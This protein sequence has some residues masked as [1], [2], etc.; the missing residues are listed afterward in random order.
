MINKIMKIIA[1]V[2]SNYNPYAIR[3]EKN[4]F[5]SLEG[6]KYRQ[7]PVK[8]LSLIQEIN[9][10][11]NDTAKMIY[12]TSFGKYQIMGYNIYGTCGYK[13]DIATFLC[14]EEHQSD[15]ALKYLQSLMVNFDNVFSSLNTL[16]K[17]KKGYMAEKKSYEEFLKNLS[18][19]LTSY[20]E[21]HSD[22]INFIQKYN[23]SRFP[24]TNFFG[25][26]LRMIHFYEKLYLG[27]A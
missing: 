12:S 15:C 17:I 26:L 21:A 25:Y 3:F 4:I 18:E 6:S 23:G 22:I 9:K 14:V 2:E 5:A 19:Y 13:Y 8:I 24:S 20:K 7:K 1:Y 10:C 11:N 27:G 16:S